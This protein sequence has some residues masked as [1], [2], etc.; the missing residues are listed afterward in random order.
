MMATAK[1]E[2]HINI[3]EVKSG[4][5]VTIP[6]IKAF[7]NFAVHRCI[8][9]HLSK[10]WALGSLGPIPLDISPSK[11]NKMAQ[12]ILETQQNCVNSEFDA[13]LKKVYSGMSESEIKKAREY[14]KNIYA[15]KSLRLAEIKETFAVTEIYYAVSLF[16]DP[17]SSPVLELALGWRSPHTLYTKTDAESFARNLNFMV[18]SDMAIKLIKFNGDGG[19]KKDSK[20]KICCQQITKSLRKGSLFDVSF[21]AQLRDDL[22]KALEDEGY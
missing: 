16:S 17:S 14:N 13:K 4:E 5:V 21:L 9:W 2:L 12:D 3:F 18:P 15:Q 10:S 6:I 8:S 20:V 11:H 1:K 7:G 19:L 22:K